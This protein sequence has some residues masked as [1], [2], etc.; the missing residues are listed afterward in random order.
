MCRKKWILGTALMLVL[1]GLSV[2]YMN[3][4]RTVDL[5]S[6]QPEMAPVIE[7]VMEARM[8][9]IS[10]TLQADR[11]RLQSF[12]EV[13]A[14]DWSYAEKGRDLDVPFGEAKGDLV[15]VL[16]GKPKVDL[17]TGLIVFEVPLRFMSRVH[18]EGEIFGLRPSLSED[19]E[20]ALRARIF[21]RPRFT[22][23]WLLE[24][25]SRVEFEWTREP[26][27]E[28]LGYRVSLKPWIS[29]V[30]EDWLRENAERI[31]VEINEE[32]RLGERAA[33]G[34]ERLG[35]PLE[36]RADPGLWLSIEPL[37]VHIPPPEIEEGLFRTRILVPL[38]LRLVSG[39]R[40]AFTDPGPLPP[41]ATDTPRID[42]LNLAVPVLLRYED[43]ETEARRHFA[44][45][46]TPVGDDGSLKVEDVSVEG[47][48]GELLVGLDLSG[49]KGRVG[50]GGRVYLRGSP[51]YDP[52]TGL[53]RIDDL[54]F[55]TV[56]EGRLSRVAS[57][58]LKPFFLDNFGQKLVFSVGELL[59]EARN[60]LEEDWK[61]HRLDRNL[62]LHGSILDLRL[63]RVFPA[64]GGLML[65]VEATGQ[66]TLDFEP[67]E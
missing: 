51:V 22:P 20:G 4:L 26:A 47:G 50:L 1:L 10:T 37:A 36:L 64:T 43:F 9:L 13:E 46:E 61:E 16:D 35:E 65:E 53:I 62:V 41:L 58:L 60:D 42:G 11:E 6:G 8:S 45:W 67:Q 34:W 59:V 54:R 57:W 19:L 31:D 52:E 15:V 55:D 12:L 30:L 32:L 56:T 44:G 66:A 5:G 38:N 49:R 18:W 40:P 24:T 17:K 48:G 21:M 29:P 7:P 39:Q 25:H 63:K 28:L 3:R 33:E 23:Q 14:E 2:F 27:V